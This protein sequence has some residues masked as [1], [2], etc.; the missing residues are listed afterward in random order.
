M[1]T[2]IIFFILVIQLISYKIASSQDEIYLSKK[3]LN[4]SGKVYAAFFNSDFIVLE[5]FEHIK[6]NTWHTFLDTLRYN[7]LINKYIGKKSVLISDNDVQKIIEIN[8]N[9]KRYKIGALIFEPANEYEKIKWHYRKNQILLQMLLNQEDNLTK[10][11]QLKYKRRELDS[12]STNSRHLE[13]SEY[14]N[15]LMNE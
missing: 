14:V 12:M 9:T 11:H 7:K 3:A 13:F 1:K 10:L 5:S 8:S 15:K 2:K 4:K 6:Q